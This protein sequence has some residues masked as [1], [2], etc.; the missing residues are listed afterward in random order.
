MPLQEWGGAVLEWQQDQAED[1]GSTVWHVGAKDSDWFAPSPARFMI[2][3]RVDNMQALLAKLEAADIP[4]L[5]GPEYHENGVFAWIEDPQGNKVEL[6]E[7]MI[8]DDKNRR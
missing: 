2:N 6:W 8:W 7:P 4:L 5:Q 1:G 3:Y